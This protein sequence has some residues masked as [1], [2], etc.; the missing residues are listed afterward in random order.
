MTNQSMLLPVF[1]QVTLTFVL[2]FSMAISRTRALKRK[3]V[4]MADIALGQMNWPPRVAQISNAYRNQF[5]LPVL[6]FVLAALA[7]ATGQVTTVLVVLAWVFVAFRVLH[8]VI[9]TGSN[10]VPNRFYAFA[11]SVFSLIAMW[12]VFAV[13]IMSA[14]G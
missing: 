11:G 1:A 9:H 4:R 14:A 2:L 7:I 12:A 13:Q 10:Y 3:D 8:A 5:E 6:F